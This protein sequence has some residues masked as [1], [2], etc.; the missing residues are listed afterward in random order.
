MK[1]YALYY[2]DTFVVAFPNREDCVEYG[3]K[4]YGG[5]EWD[6]NITE[7]WIYATKQ[8]PTIQPIPYS[9]PF[10][11]H[12]TPPIPCKTTPY[13]PNIWCGPKASK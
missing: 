4:H 12:Y 7:R 9:Q 8:Y 5:Y 6:C 1:I 3:K 11:T 2:K 10:I 13:E